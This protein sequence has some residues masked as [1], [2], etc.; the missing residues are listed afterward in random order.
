MKFEKLTIEEYTRFQKGHPYNNFL[1][2]IETYEFEIKEGHECE[3]VGMKEGNEVL[4]ACFLMKYPMMK[5]FSYYYAPRGFLIDYSDVELLKQ[6]TKELIR[7]CRKKGIVE[8]IVDPYI[9]I[10]ER[11]QE[12]QIVENGFHHKDILNTLQS[13]GYIHKGFSIG[14]DS[15]MQGMRW[16]YAMD[17]N[18]KTKDS[19]WKSLHQ[20]TRWSINRT[21]K[22]QMQVRDLSIDELDIFVDILNQTG[23]RRGF[24]T[25][26]KSF[27]VN[28]MNCYKDKMKCKLAYLDIS[29]LKK[30]LNEEKQSLLMDLSNVELKLGQVS[31]SKKFNKKKKVVLEALEINEKRYKEANSLEQQYGTIIPMAAST[32]IYDQD[33]VIYLMSGA[34]EEFRDFYASYAIQ[35]NVIQEALD[36]GYNKYNFYGI[37]GN[38]DPE[39]ENYGVYAFKKGF[40]GRVEELIGDFDLPCRPFLYQLNRKIKN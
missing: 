21:I 10:Q 38:F 8:V 25:R 36:M 27:F 20:Q 39:D 40:P 34:Y 16:M 30:Y 24:E 19:L 1:N 15:N 18:G 33:E 23:K 2:S 17:L 28:Q 9:L 37:S 4:C 31:N 12:G 5:C 3:L 14:Y 35:W 6:F 26:D 7:F 32:F 22:Y 11:N 13:L 29:L